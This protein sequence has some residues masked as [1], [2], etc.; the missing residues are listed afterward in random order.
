MTIIPHL[1]L[2]TVGAQAMGL[3]GQ[4]LVLAYVFGYGV[5]LVDHPIKF[6]LYF[7]K[8]RFRNEKNYHW[9]TPLQEPVA[10]LWIVPLCVYL[11]SFV[12]ALFFLSHV[13]LDYL[14]QYEKRPFFPFSTFATQGFL[15]QLS[16]GRKELAVS[17]VSAVS[18]AVLNAP[19]LFRLI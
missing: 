12:P 3:D 7:K 5:D 13:L 8:N 6:P 11:G 4:D 16:D 9:R 15:S 14:V 19:L 18:L 10:L 17:I 1:L 2:T